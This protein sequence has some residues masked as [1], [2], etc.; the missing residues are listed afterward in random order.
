MTYQPHPSPSA[1]AG[2]VV[3]GWEGGDV[4]YYNEW[5]PYAADWLRNLIDAGLIPLGYVDERSISDVQSE[6][7]DGYT[8][9][10]FFCGIG[11]WCEALRLA[12]WP[13]DVPVWTGSC[14]CQPFS[15][16]GK[17]KGITD[18]RHLWP[19]FYR[20]IRECRPATVFGEQV[21]SP[22]GWAWLG[23]LRADMEAS[24]Y[25]VG[26]GVLPAACVGSPQRRH[27]I[28]WVANANDARRERA[29]R[30]RQ[31]RA[32][33]QGGTSA[34]R[35]SVRSVSRPWPPG[36]SEVDSIPLLV[37][38]LPGVVGACAA[39]GNAIVPHVAAEFVRACA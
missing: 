19:E 14:P 25:A 38:G 36:P 29:V 17:R 8:Q 33:G 22:A 37:N 27:R 26:G 12:A 5:N 11:G 9:C 6:D 10:H 1:A 39:Y 3:G 28:Y 13:D 23:A 30:P 34:C 32:K 2:R 16:A 15:G 21:E 35:K 4:N 20:L 18:E 7:L 31:P 24:S